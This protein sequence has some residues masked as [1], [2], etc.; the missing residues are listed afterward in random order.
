MT[1]SRWSGSSSTS[2][3]SA[4]RT[5][6][7]R[8]SRTSWPARRC[9]TRP[10]SYYNK[11]KLTLTA[12]DNGCAGIDTTEYRID[13]GAW[14]AYADPFDVTAPGAHTVEYRTTDRFDNV[15]PVGSTSFTIVAINDSAAPQTTLQ[16]N[17]AAPRPRYGT[18]VTLRLD[19]TDP[20]GT[21]ES[22][23]VKSTEYSINGA[24][25]VKL[26]PEKLPHTLLVP[27]SGA[28]TIDYHSVDSAGN[29]EAT[30]QVAFKIDDGLELLSCKGSTSDSFDGPALNPGLGTTC[31]PSRRAGAWWAAGSPSTLSLRRPGRPNGP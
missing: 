27:G 12:A 31:A 28:Y 29:A 24:T 5:P 11:V 30:K 7:P 3:T 21:G 10:G 1:A 17:G 19:A 25:P 13:S 20:A 23:G 2:R 6:S 26:T 14:N 9:P 18:Q 4:T 16:I 22:S 15:S 8:A